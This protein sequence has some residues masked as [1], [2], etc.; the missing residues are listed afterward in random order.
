M[1]RGLVLCR[2]LAYARSRL[3]LMRRRTRRAVIVR[4]SVRCARAMRSRLALVRVSRRVQRLPGRFWSRSVTPIVR[5]RWVIRRWSGSVVRALLIL[6]GAGG[7]VCCSGE[8]G[9]WH[10]SS[11]L[12]QHDWDWKRLHVRAGERHCCWPG[13]DALALAALFA[14]GAFT[15]GFCITGALLALTTP[16]P[17]KAAGFGVAATCGRP[18]FTDAHWARSESAILSC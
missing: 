13:A 15:A 10:C 4:R 11:A 18:R 9:Y 17:W 7:R 2:R 6:P 14:R 1:R 8:G 12:L 16:V 3:V 5:H